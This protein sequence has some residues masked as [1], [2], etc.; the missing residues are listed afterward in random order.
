MF[1][2]AMRSPDCKFF[3]NPSGLYGSFANTPTHYTNQNVFNFDNR[4]LNA[5][6]PMQPSP[7]HPSPM[8]AAHIQA[9]PNMSM[10]KEPMKNFFVFPT[11][12]VNQMKPTDMSRNLMTFG[13]KEFQTKSETPSTFKPDSQKKQKPTKRK[14]LSVR[15]DVM[16]KNIFRAFKR[17]LKRI[18][19]EFVASERSNDDNEKSGSKFLQMVKLF[20]EHSLQQNGINTDGI[21]GFNSEVYGTYIGIM[22]DYC[23]MKKI[24]K[25]AE[26]RE[27]LN[28]TF[29]VIYSYSHQKFYD[30]LEIP[31]IKVICK[32]VIAQTGIDGLI[33]NNDS[34]Q[35]D[36]YQSHIVQLMDKL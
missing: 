35:K 5:R 7:M 29:N 25:G 18:Y 24:L 15:E 30:F 2:D 36:K 9:S 1:N 4:Y 34:L 20:T 28:A 10:M 19:S 32:M 33:S 11:V 13:E 26:D 27:R 17:E 22:L 3:F 16:N 12:P 6:S 23:Q 14:N 31:E 21:S 8:P